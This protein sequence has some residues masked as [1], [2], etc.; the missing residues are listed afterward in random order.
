MKR[1]RERKMLS[2]YGLRVL[3][4]KVTVSLR[5]LRSYTGEMLHSLQQARGPQQ[6]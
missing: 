4:W 5:A 6:I 3:M 2:A 1:E